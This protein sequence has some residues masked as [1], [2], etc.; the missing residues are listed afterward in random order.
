MKS[1]TIKE[2]VRLLKLPEVKQLVALGRDS[3]YCGVREGT[4]PAPRKVGE[5]AVAWRSDE[6]EAWIASR[7]LATA[8][9]SEGSR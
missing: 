7:P 3:I 6:I 1:D 9:A 4:F 5:R 8:A 2:P